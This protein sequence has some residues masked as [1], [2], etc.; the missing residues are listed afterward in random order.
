MGLKTF[1][2]NLLKTRQQVQWDRYK[3]KYEENRVNFLQAHDNIRKLI[4]EFEIS[5]EKEKNKTLFEKRIDALKRVNKK[6]EVVRERLYSTKVEE[7][8]LELSKDY[9]AKTSEEELE[10]QMKPFDGYSIE[11][12]SDKILKLYEPSVDGLKFEARVFFR[13][14]LRDIY[15]D[16][17]IEEIDYYSLLVSSEETLRKGTLLMFVDDNGATKIVKNRYGKMGIIK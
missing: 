10:K 2:S 11:N 8:S 6:M 5:A 17:K 7:L 14:D 12:D 4:Q 16:M 3:I 13:K 9:L 15:K 1:F